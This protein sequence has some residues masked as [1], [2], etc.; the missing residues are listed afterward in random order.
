MKHIA[1][2]LGLVLQ[3][4]QLILHNA[5]ITDENA[6]ELKECFH[7]FDELLFEHCTISVQG[8]KTILEENHAKD[9][10]LVSSKRKIQIRRPVIFFVRLVFIQA[11]LRNISLLLR[12]KMSASRAYEL[13]IYH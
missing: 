9:R 13:N 12:R 5:V 11:R 7:R 1:Q 2:V 6:T 8:M 3:I 10:N 4:K